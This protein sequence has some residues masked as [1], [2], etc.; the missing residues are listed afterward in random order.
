MLLAQPGPLERKGRRASPAWR[1]PLGRKG[2]Q[3]QAG[4][5]EQLEPRAT[6]VRPAR[7][8]WLVPPELRGQQGRKATQGHRDQLALRVP[9]GRKVSKDRQALPVPPEP[10][11]RQDPLGPRVTRATQAQRDRQAH[12]G[13]RVL[14]EQLVQLARRGLQAR[15]ELRATQD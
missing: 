4:Q 1:E 9:R 7:R 10:L 3:V 15:L 11:V 5:L 8:V 13:R 14:R 12:K 2:Q 6:L